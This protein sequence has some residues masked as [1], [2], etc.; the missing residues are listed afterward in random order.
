MDESGIVLDLIS[1][2]GQLPFIGLIPNIAKTVNKGRKLFK[3]WWI[4]R[5]QKEL[6]NLPELDVKEILERLPMFFAADL[7]DYLLN[8]D[9][10]L[11]S[12]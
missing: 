10:K 6:Y 5:G 12:R 3:E 7:K 11:K 8:E 1:T 2:L 4:K 9:S